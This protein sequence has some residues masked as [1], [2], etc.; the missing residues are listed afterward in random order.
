ML[1]S[2]TPSPGANGIVAKI[3]MHGIRKTIGARLKIGRSAA[4]G[5]QVFL[6]HQLQRVGD[7]LQQPVRPDAV[8]TDARLHARRELPLEQRHVGEDADERA[9]HDG[10]R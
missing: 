3:S 9:E 4:V 7:R 10:R 1:R 2:A 5:H 6:H 8:R